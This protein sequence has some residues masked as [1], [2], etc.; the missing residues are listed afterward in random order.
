MGA[1]GMVSDADEIREHVGVLILV[2]HCGV[3]EFRVCTTTPGKPGT[4]VRR[5]ASRG[6]GSTFRGS[7]IE[8]PLGTDSSGKWPREENRFDWRFADRGGP[9]ALARAPPFEL[10][11]TLG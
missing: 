9:V 6:H 8:P 11:G 7:S 1:T 2:A 4:C 3:V 5:A 10:R